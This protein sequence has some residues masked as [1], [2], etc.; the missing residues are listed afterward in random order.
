V[1][2]GSSLSR[3]SN[4]WYAAAKVLAGLLPPALVFTYA[5]SAGVVHGAQDALSLIVRLLF[6]M[7]MAFAL[8]MGVAEKSAF[9][10]RSGVLQ[11]TACYV[12]YVVFF[13]VV[14]FILGV[15][16][17]YAESPNMGRYQW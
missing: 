8:V 12:L 7:V 4:G 6:C 5:A 10:A 14:A 13:F 1:A 15:E 3:E 11:Q 17:R 16:L 9:F 2:G